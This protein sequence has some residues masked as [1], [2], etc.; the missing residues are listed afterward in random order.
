MVSLIRRDTIRLRDENKSGELQSVRDE[1]HTLIH[2]RD[3]LR[4]PE[5]THT[6]VERGL[7]HRKLYSDLV[8]VRTLVHQVKVVHQQ[9]ES[10]SQ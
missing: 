3:S 6:R 4:S 5:L 9:D 8:L 10:H 7:Y 2:A 1:G